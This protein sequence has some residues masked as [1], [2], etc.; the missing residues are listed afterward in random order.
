MP[1]RS[2]P[3][4]VLFLAIGSCALL[5]LL[6][7]T[8]AWY[9]HREQN[10]TVTALQEDIRS[11]GAA[12][13]LETSLNNL[14]IL[15]DRQSTEVGALQDQVRADI[16]E[17]VRLADKNEEKQLAARVTELFDEYLRRWQSGD[18]PAVLALFLR[19]RIVPALIE[20]RLYNGREL[21]Q[22]EED[23]RRALGQMAWGLVIVSGLGAVAGIILGYGLAR[24]LR[25][26]I[27]H[28]LVRVQ[29]ASD[30][31]AQ[32]IPLVEWQ[33]SGEPLRDGSDDLA[34]RVEQVVSKLQQRE[35]EVR[36]AE[37]LAAVGQL[38]AGVAHEIRN[39]LTSI[40]MLVQ[41]GLE[42]QEPMPAEDCRVIEGE[43]RRMERSLQTFLDFARPPKPQ[44][45]VLDLRPVVEDVLEL[46]RPRAEKQKVTVSRNLQSPRLVGDAE[47]LRQVL[48]NL[49]LNALDAMPN[50]GALTVTL[51]TA[52]QQI[53]IEVADD[54]PGI[55]KAVF[56][57]LFEPFA[58]S[59]DT[60]LGLGL[61]ISKRI[62]EDHGGKINAANRPG[63]GASF[64]IRLPGAAASA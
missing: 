14:A 33:R 50:G 24:S 57:R 17:V 51:K 5:L 63:G 16:A 12:I 1:I 8:V 22:S 60:G 19:E 61:V 25:R 21:K 30:K 46:I 56:P 55:P 29:G 58:S 35:R 32:E 44:R 36:R 28:F 59:K 4:R 15:H 10:A 40:K 18:R 47:Q 37:R 48:V 41:A 20:L 43:V 31:L 7:G 6:G 34:H 53:E 49:L 13:V 11:R 9:L 39:P 45:K 26:T 64:F 52:G 3:G 42:D 23:H 27:H 2:Y 38:A 54:G 62:V